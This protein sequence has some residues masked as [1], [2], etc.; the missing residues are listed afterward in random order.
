MDGWS[1]ASN[2]ITNGEQS[3]N[4]HAE[5][6]PH[7]IVNIDVDDRERKINNPN[8]NSFWEELDEFGTKSTHHGVR[9][10]TDRQNHVL[11]R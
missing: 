5:K 6:T 7:T 9:F 11:R 1:A 8:A 3:W 2:H 10:V 4:N